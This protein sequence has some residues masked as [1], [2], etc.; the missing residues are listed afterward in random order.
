MNI[1]LTTTHPG[2]GGPAGLGG[3]AGWA[4]PP[5]SPPY[6]AP[7]A[8]RMFQTP[9]PMASGAT[10]P[11]GCDAQGAN[12]H[13][14]PTIGL[15]TVPPLGPS[16]RDV[17][18]CVPDMLVLIKH[19]ILE[20]DPDCKFKQR[21]IIRHGTHPFRRYG[22]VISR[23]RTLL[24]KSAC[25]HPDVLGFISMSTLKHKVEAWRV[26]FP[27]MA[28]LFAELDLMEINVPAHRPPVRAGCACLLV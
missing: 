23:C 28:W 20:L 21:E 24:W 11:R 9:A 3:L 14:W 27:G 2:T 5:T 8:V 22:R 4:T 6:T 10:E 15:R 12:E 13:Q 1:S 17:A 7:D 16:K 18:L 19:K 25:D 26:Q